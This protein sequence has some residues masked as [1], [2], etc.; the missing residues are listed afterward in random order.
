MRVKNFL[1]HRVSSQKDVMWPPMEPKQFEKTIRFLSKKYQ[2]VAI[3][4][5]LEKGDWN[6]SNKPIATI[7][8]DDG[9]K[10]NLEFAAPILQ[11]YKCPASFYVVTQ[12]IN[13]NIPTWT[14]CV[15][16]FFRTYEKRSLAL[17]YDFVPGEFQLVKWE[18]AEQSRVLSRKF[19]TWL[20]SLS[21]KKRLIVMDEIKN[22]SANIELPKE[23]MMNWD[24]IRQLKQAGFYIGSHSHT[25]PM[26][27]SLTDEKEIEYELKKSADIIEQQLG[28]YPTTI[29]YPIGS[30]DDR[31]VKMAKKTGYKIG[32]IV[33][34]K[35][36]N[37]RF[38]DI[39]TV[40]R[41]ELYSESWWKTRLKI[42]G[43]YQSA[44]KL[45]K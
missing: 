36:Y 37:P 30:W 11:K 2:I 43:I 40:P 24:E 31:V 8:F 35:F 1:F 13:E 23:L 15:D 6:K 44:R 34:Q 19:K 38:D 16:F 17:N 14:Y 10:D 39:M 25:H 12:C 7:L 42:N 4:N 22:Q 5:F 27:A 33:G 20:K 28:Y 45:L 18:T 26:L 3:E 29:S 32:L 41:V 21:N 9:Y